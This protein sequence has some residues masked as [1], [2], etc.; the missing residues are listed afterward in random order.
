MIVVLADLS[1]VENSWSIIQ[2]RLYKKNERLENADQ[3][4]V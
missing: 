3:V 4:Q 2:D 1:P